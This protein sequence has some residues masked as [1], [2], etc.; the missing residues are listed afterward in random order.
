MRNVV[1]EDRFIQQAES[2]LEPCTPKEAARRLGEAADSHI[3]DRLREASYARKI[4]PI[5][6]FNK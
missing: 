4:L 6:V 5:N 1:D 2:D 3:R